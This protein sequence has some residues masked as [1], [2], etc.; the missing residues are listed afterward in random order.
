MLE[1]STIGLGNWTASLEL[2]EPMVT[3]SNR[4]DKEPRNKEGPPLPEREGGREGGGGEGGEEGV[5]DNDI[6]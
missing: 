1:F 2:L 6:P 4:S 5:F 3:F